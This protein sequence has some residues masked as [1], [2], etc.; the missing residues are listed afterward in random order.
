MIIWLASY[1]RSGNNLFASLIKQH[2]REKVYSIYDEVVTFPYYDISSNQVIDSVYPFYLNSE[3][4]QKASES[5]QVFFVKTHELPQKNDSN[6]AVYLVRDGRDVMISYAHYIINDKKSVPTDLNEEPFE[7]AMNTLINSSDQF[8]GWGPHVL[9]W[10]S[11]S[12]KTIIV[13]YEDLISINQQLSSLNSVI[14]ELGVEQINIVDQS[15]L[16]NFDDFRSTN[17][18]LYRKGK[19]GSWVTEMSPAHHLR[20]WEC[21]GDAMLRMGYKYDADQ[22][23][24]QRDFAI[25]ETLNPQNMRNLVQSKH[26]LMEELFAKEEV[27]QEIH[28]ANQKLTEELIAKE[29][30]IQEIHRQL[31]AK[32]QV[33]Q[34]I[35]QTNQKLTDELAVKEKIIMEFQKTFVYKFQKIVSSFR[36]PS[37]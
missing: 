14:K 5:D 25:K 27:I 32:E 24:L 34:D 29:Q 37:S 21:Y 19:T 12:A 1:P 10:T 33:V 4:L 13:K 31:V 9:S 36:K 2:L 20:F 30:A 3:Q 35:H 28:Q 18:V 23:A 22:I 11:R 16:P 15:P 17:P 8:G 7:W 6:L 26:K